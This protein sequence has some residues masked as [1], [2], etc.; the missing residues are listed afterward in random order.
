LL[1]GKKTSGTSR[2]TIDD[3]KR[4]PF[5]VATH[6]IFPNFSDTENTGSGYWDVDL[7]SNGFKFK[8]AEQETNSSGQSFIYM[9][10]AEAP[11]VG[12]N[13]VTAK[14]R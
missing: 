8:T 7:L 9:A 2:W 1:C 14:A 6:G 4:D 5:N 10:F 11:L 13:G 3:N 12:S